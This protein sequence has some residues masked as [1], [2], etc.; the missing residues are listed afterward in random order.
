VARVLIVGCGCRGRLLA[1]E[2]VARGH[3][4][5]GTTRGDSPG[6]GQISAVGAE[7]FVGD[8]D[9]VGTLFAALDGVTILCVLLGSASG[10]LEALAAL[11]GTRLEMLLHKAIDTTVRGIVYESRGSVDR[12]LLDAGAE[13]VATACRYSQIPYALLDADPA[14]DAAWLA[15][16]VDAIEG[17]LGP[18]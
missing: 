9:R 13:A 18:R 17:L 14:D 15:A 4:V 10:S 8:P 11:H 7:P 6:S 1:G 3:A 12:A 16:G 2:L 5:R